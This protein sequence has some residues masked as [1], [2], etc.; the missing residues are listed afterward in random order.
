MR[1]V[2]VGWRDCRPYNP[3]AFPRGVPINIEEGPVFAPVSK[4]YMCTERL[5]IF[6]RNDLIGPRVKENILSWIQNL[7][8]NGR[9]EFRPRA[10]SLLKLLSIK[11]ENLGG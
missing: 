8:V 6:V 9:V 1:H 4:M 10:N 7:Q 2:V 3:A 5:F 11:I